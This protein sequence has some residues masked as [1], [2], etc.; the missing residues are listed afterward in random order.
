MDLSAATAFLNPADILSLLP[1]LGNAPAASTS[2]S[3]C[4]PQDF[5]AVLT[6]L[7]GPGDHEADSS[8]AVAPAPAI[9]PPPS[10]ATAPV[11]H[12]A[13]ADPRTKQLQKPT[14]NTVTPHGIVDISLTNA[15]VPF[16]P[17]AA[18]FTAAPKPGDVPAPVKTG[19][20]N[21][22]P[23]VLQ[24]GN[25][26]SLSKPELEQAFADVRTFEYTV[27]E[28]TANQP[29]VPPS[30]EPAHV[31]VNADSPKVTTISASTQNAA[32]PLVLQPGPIR[33]VADETKPVFPVHAL[34]PKQNAP[35]PREETPAASVDAG[36]SKADA[37]PIAHQAVAAPFARQPES[38]QALT[39]E[40]K[41]ARPVPL[42]TAKQNITVPFEQLA[43]VS[44]EAGSS[45]EDV[46]P[47][48]PQVVTA[49]PEPEF[50]PEQGVR[51]IKTPEC[52]IQVQTT[53]QNANG[54]REPEADPAP[55]EALRAAPVTTDAIAN[56][57]QQL[58][59]LR[60]IA[61]QKIV[62]ETKPV[63]KNKQGPAPAP[64]DPNATTPAVQASDLIRPVDR[65]D[66]PVAAHPIEIPNIPHI[67]VVRT[68]SMEVGDSDSQVTIRIQERG[69]N[70][71]LQLNA[72]SEGL[73]RD[74]QASVGSL[75]HALKQEDVQVSRIEVSRKSPIDKVR[76]MKEAR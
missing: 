70:I 71:A 32:A 24:A 56:V 14:I 22:S 54:Q 34:T 18:A 61:V 38:V 25:S 50:Q 15:T 40:T 13:T 64:A 52:A 58:L 35:E 72:G 60:V 67:P 46:T 44:L 48:A 57:Q 9:V 29:V 62:T 49:P 3:V 28:E 10:A 39:D 59:P 33:I 63:E 20:T 19:N 1:L 76:R 75:E 11:A 68:V 47:T 31:L 66:R 53:K 8:T 23:S 5:S 65:L 69:G 41:S 12:F 21:W 45:K 36:S 43:A 7:T 27:Q 42:E 17:T 4:S 26:S 2:F 51:D 16:P 55:V 37:P 6:E 30:P 74:L 73:Q